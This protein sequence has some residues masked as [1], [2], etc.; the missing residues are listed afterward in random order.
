MHAPY[1]GYTCAHLCSQVTSGQLWVLY[2]IFIDCC[3]EADQYLCLAWWESLR[4]THFTVLLLWGC[5]GALLL[6]LLYRGAR[7]SSLKQNCS[8][9]YISGW[10]FLQTEWWTCNFYGK[11]N[12]H[13]LVRNHACEDGSDN[14]TSYN[15]L[16]W[17]QRWGVPMWKSRPAGWLRCQ[18]EQG[19]TTPVALHVLC[20]HPL[21]CVQNAYQRAF[22]L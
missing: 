6:V 13:W 14:W 11:V 1:D 15:I 20:S 16:W 4:K 19:I 9:A 21:P 12:S 3:A 5:L 7:W 10:V 18:L 22:M 2:H 17:Q 8:R